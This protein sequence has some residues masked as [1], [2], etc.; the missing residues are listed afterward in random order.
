[1]FK[2]AYF[3]GMS[4]LI[5]KIVLNNTI[6]DFFGFYLIQK[7][8][9]I[10]HYLIQKFVLNNLKKIPDRE[11]LRVSFYASRSHP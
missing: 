3:L 2:F 6:L 4:Y 1:M 5:Q 9:L 11:T 7:I 10:N 8:V